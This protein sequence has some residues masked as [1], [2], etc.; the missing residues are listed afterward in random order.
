MI[1]RYREASCD[2]LSNGP[3]PES[4][5]VEVSLLLP[6]MQASILEQLAHERGLTAGEMVR[7]LIRDFV[8]HGKG[9]TTKLANLWP[10]TA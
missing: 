10:R 8:G 7:T 2:L 9:V 6:V 3:G 5:I 4:D 1:D